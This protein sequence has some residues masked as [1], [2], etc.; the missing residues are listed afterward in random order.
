M[1]SNF[2]SVSTTDKDM[3]DTQYKRGKVLGTG[4]VTVESFSDDIDERDG[5]DKG[6]VTVLQNAYPLK[7]MMPSH[8]SRNNCVWIYPVTFGGGLVGGDGIKMNFVVKQNCSVLI[9]GQESTKVYHCEDNLHTYQSTVGHVEQGGLLCVLSDPVVCY[10]DSVFTQTQ[11]FHMDKGGNLV[12]L[13][14]LIGGRVALDELW[15]LKSYRNKTDVFVEGTLVYR[16]NY[17]LCDKGPVAIE[18]AMRSFQV[19]GSCI[20]LGDK[21]KSVCSN[22]SA[23]LG[24][25]KS[26]GEQ[27]DTEL[28]CS[29]STLNYV[30]E[31]KST[32]SGL[33]IRFMASN[34]T[35]AYSDVVSHI[36]KELNPIVGGDPFA[37][38]Y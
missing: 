16:D 1:M 27:Y 28:V 31:D 11:E 4:A 18:Q 15:Q 23:I 33:Y 8:A 14:W 9:T 26:I 25:K 34:S 30:L 32:L 36:V 21:L 22:L 10:K 37:E 35:K 2:P 29:V 17:L 19:I 13:D 5:F 6:Y 38:K 12:Y 3:I 20:L 24:Q 7:L